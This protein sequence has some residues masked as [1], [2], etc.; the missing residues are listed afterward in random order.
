MRLDFGR[1]LL[2]ARRSHLF[3]DQQLLQLF[4]IAVLFLTEL[5]FGLAKRKL[6]FILLNIL[7]PLWV[8]ALRQLLDLLE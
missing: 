7:K 3:A 6:Y 4:L 8:V 1:D 2:R 5:H